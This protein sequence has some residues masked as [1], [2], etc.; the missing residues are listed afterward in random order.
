MAA[1]HSA[2]H[3]P[4]L[5]KE[6]PS[7]HEAGRVLKLLMCQLLPLAHC[8]PTEA[9][10]DTSKTVEVCERKGK[11]KGIARLVNRM[12]HGEGDHC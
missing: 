11:I 7:L 6:G 2:S 10:Q 1:R 9:S 5:R 12:W 4:E 8:P 3:W